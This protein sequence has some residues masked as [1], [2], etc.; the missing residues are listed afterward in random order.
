MIYAGFKFE[1]VPNWEGIMPIKAPG[2]YKKPETIAKYIAERKA[3]MA[4]GMAAESML[5]GMVTEV[6]M[7]RDNEQIQVIS[8]A[9]ECVECLTTFL[10]EEGGVVGYRIHRAMKLMVL[11]RMILD[12]LISI[13]TI[14]QIDEHHNRRAGF[15]DPVSLIFGSGTDVSAVSLRLNI[16]LNVDMGSAALAEFARSLVKNVDLG[17]E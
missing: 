15:V 4:G 10:N 1:P 2:N 8:G 14:R 16:P 5:T 12:Q 17:S 9:T 6:A 13:D 11:G 3:D 7:V